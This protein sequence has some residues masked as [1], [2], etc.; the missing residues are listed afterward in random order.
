MQ[1]PASA[2]ATHCFC[3]WPAN[4]SARPANPDSLCFLSSRPSP[5]RHDLFFSGGSRHNRAVKPNVVLAS[6]ETVRTDQNVFKVRGGAVEGCCLAAQ[7]PGLCAAACLPGCSRRHNLPPRSP[8]LASSFHRPP[9]CLPLVLF[10]VP[11]TAEHQ[12]G[13]VHHR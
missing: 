11:P 6:Y 13:D 1:L 3:A 8:Q 4:Q 7:L 9:G 2:P 12:L 10:V 5:Q